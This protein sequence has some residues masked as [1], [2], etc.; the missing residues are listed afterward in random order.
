MDYKALAHRMHDLFG[1]TA[2]P[3]VFQYWDNAHE[4]S[5]PI[6]SSEDRPEAGLTS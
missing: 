4:N 3:K 1:G 5:V 6:M 2:T